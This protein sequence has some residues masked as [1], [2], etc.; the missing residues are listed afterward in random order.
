MVER[1]WEQVMEPML[2]PVASRTEVHGP[3]WQA[4]CFDCGW[5]GDAVDTKPEAVLEGNI[6]RCLP[7]PQQHWERMGVWGRDGFEDVPFP[8]EGE[9]E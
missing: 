9:G 2:R 6:H 5:M 4:E 7:R 8:F 3:M 1:A